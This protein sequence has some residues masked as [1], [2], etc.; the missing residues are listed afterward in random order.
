MSALADEVVKRL[1]RKREPVS[2]TAKQVDDVLQRHNV[3][4][5]ASTSTPV[6]LR[7]A[8]LSFRGVK[9]LDPSHPAVT[10]GTANAKTGKVEVPF[11]FEWEPPVGVLGIGTGKNLRG[12]STV[13]HVLTWAL[14]GRRPD[15]KS[16]VTAWLKKVEV[17]WTVGPDVVRVRFDVSGGEPKDG[18]VELVGV[19]G[20]GALEVR[21]LATF[22]DADEFEGVM[23][24]VMMGRLRLAEIPVWTKDRQVNH[25]WPSFSSSMEVRHNQ[26]DPIVG[27]VSTLAV[28][29]MQAFIGTDWVIANAA[30]MSALRRLETAAKDESDRAS[31]ASEVAEEALGEAQAVV[32]ALEGQLAALGDDVPDVA[33]VMSSA[34]RATDLAREAHGLERQLM[35]EAA[36]ADTLRLQI[37]ASKARDHALVEDAQAT[38][39][40]HQMEPTSCPRCTTPVEPEQVAAEHDDDKC[41]L[42][43]K[44]LD[45]VTPM[46]ETAA[47]VP[48]YEDEGDDEG[49]VDGV[50]AL[51][52]GVTESE[53]R[54]SDLRDRLNQLYAEGDAARARYDADR[55]R[56]AAGG[57][58]SR[59][60]LEL[61]TANGVVKALSGQRAVTTDGSKPTFD[62]SVLDAAN[63]I[64]TARVAAAQKAYLGAISMDISELVA[65]FGAPHLT[66]FAL[67]GNANMN[68]KTNGVDTTYG[69]L[70]DGEKLRVKIATAIAL[71]R[72]G[73]AAGLGRH[74]GFLIMDSP[75][76]EEM[77]DSDLATMVEALLDVAGDEQMQI[78][79]ATRSAQPLVDLLPDDHRRVVTGE[80]YLW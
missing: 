14:T 20:D 43:S 60:Q 11:A 57:D 41:S 71:I 16:D 45:S 35:N 22:A 70:V 51:E 62:L 46:S 59:L 52:S 49:G 13:L 24:A 10:G 68:V 32:A 8:K 42:C 53:A 58:R 44:N 55:N 65:K 66:D 61:A 26:L 12:K 5:T 48:G 64:L 37:R 19:G 78:V 74:P 47:E 1:S 34:T 67:S 25:T 76:A 9:N 6:P 80:D 56:I 75:A 39:F 2:A 27:N 23:G 28:R 33:E 30:A 54:M 40:F 3:P 29:M 69:G 18:F 77:P 7:V 36:S 21:Q 72:H 50:E 15:M 38:R 79:V 73:H 17:D 63:A 4:T 31:T